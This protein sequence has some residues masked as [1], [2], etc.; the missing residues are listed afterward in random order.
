MLEFIE[1]LAK[2]LGPAVI[3]WFLAKLTNDKSAEKNRKEM[4]EQL[5]IAKDNNQV[6]QLRSYRMRFCLDEL[7]VQ[8]ISIDAALREMNRFESSTRRLVR[9]KNLDALIVASNTMSFS[10]QANNAMIDRFGFLQA[11]IRQIRAG[12]QAELENLITT[13]VEDLNEYHKLGGLINECM[14]HYEEDNDENYI[15][16]YSGSI[17]SELKKHNF[18]ATYQKMINL[19][20]F[21]LEHHEVVF[22]QM[23]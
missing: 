19:R 18:S 22:R 15:N 2:V 10:T 5:R 21:I 13:L 17:K 1:E 8:D 3:A 14:F 9:E 16:T 4:R 20:N 11:M 6:V 7:K 23:N 12:S